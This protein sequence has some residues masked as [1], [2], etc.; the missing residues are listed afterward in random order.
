MSGKDKEAKHPNPG[1]HQSSKALTG[2]ILAFTL[3]METPLG[4]MAHASFITDYWLGLGFTIFCAAVVG[5]FPLGVKW[6]RATRPE[7]NQ[8]QEDAPEDGRNAH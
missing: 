4:I 5:C 6:A 8:I 1:K 3:L 2:A 7:Q